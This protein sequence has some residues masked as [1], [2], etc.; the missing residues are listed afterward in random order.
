MSRLHLLRKGISISALT[1]VARSNRRLVLTA[2]GITK[3]L[4]LRVSAVQ[5]FLSSLSPADIQKTSADAHVNRT[6]IRKTIICPCLAP[7]IF[8]AAKIDNYS[9]EN[10]YFTE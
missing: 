8:M 10:K 1:I 6:I 3:P 9:L 2:N 7:L 5:P 4:P